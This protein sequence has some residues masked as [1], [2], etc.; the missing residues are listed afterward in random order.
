MR[1]RS[2]AA[3]ARLC[4]PIPTPMGA[5]NARRLRTFN[6]RS[7][8]A[9]N[10]LAVI[11]ARHRRCPGV[12][13]GGRLARDPRY[14]ASIAPATALLRRGAS[15]RLSTVESRRS[16]RRISLPAGAPTRTAAWPAWFAPSTTHMRP[17]CGSSLAAV[18]LAGT[19]LGA[20]ALA[21][22]TPVRRS[23]RRFAPPTFAE[24]S[25]TDVRPRSLL[26]YASIDTRSMSIDDRPSTPGQLCSCGS[27]PK[28]CAPSV[29]RTSSR[30]EW[31]PDGHRA[32]DGRPPGAG[33]RVAG[34]RRHLP[35]M[36]G[37][38]VRP[39]VHERTTAATGAA[40]DQ[41][42]FPGD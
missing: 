40:D 41:P 2:S 3:P 17:S 12:A 33:D 9:R 42:W 18:A 37:T 29:S 6:D 22:A 4:S 16:S 21:K 19:A 5:W 20:V 10:A 26:R 38:R 34:A 24:H 15:R 31:I 35:E 39:L 14:R 23:S 13:A 1:R 32:R 28:S 7:R 8:G 30:Y 25:R 11:A 36:P 27:W